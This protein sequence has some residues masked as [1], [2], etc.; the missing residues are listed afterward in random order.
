MAFAKEAWGNTSGWVAAIIVTGAVC[1]GLTLFGSA[2]ATTAPTALGGDVARW[3]SIEQPTDANLILSQAAPAD[4]G[5]RYLSLA[6][7]YIAA[8][9]ERH[10]L[11]DFLDDRITTPADALPFI[12]ELS[13]LAGTAD[14]AIFASKPAKLVAYERDD[15]Q[16]EALYEIGSGA[17]K[18]ATLLAGEA[19]RDGDAAK[20]ERAE[21]LLRGV[22]ALGLHLYRER[23]V[24]R[25]LEYGY[26]LM[27][28]SL[29]TLGPLAEVGGDASRAAALRSQRI[30]LTDYVAA[31]L[32]PV[33]SAIGAI[34]DDRGTTDLAD[35]HPGDVRAI[36][37]SDKADRLWR[38]EAILRLGVARFDAS[39]PGDRQ[40]AAEL[41]NDLR[42]SG[43]ND[44]V[45]DRAVTLAAELTLAGARSSY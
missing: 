29:A 12:D 9:A 8:S 35:V 16:L 23:L 5:Q 39:R 28:E 31:T 13:D 37:A 44:P 10:R 25:E 17:S 2:S 15:A 45:T 42:A 11:E 33:W 36:A 14:V 4:A 18:Q 21:A 38:T 26:R 34:Q 1:A 43:T 30:R 22:Y 27:S 3:S 32:V 19:A 41:L 24:H 20:R 40:A 6:S 7:R